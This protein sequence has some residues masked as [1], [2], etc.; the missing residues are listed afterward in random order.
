[1]GNVSE[2]LKLNSSGKREQRLRK[3]LAIR[4][5]ELDVRIDD[6]KIKVDER[7]K[8]VLKFVTPHFR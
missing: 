5:N 2:K 6:D 4:I 3:Y 7:D 8:H 1:M